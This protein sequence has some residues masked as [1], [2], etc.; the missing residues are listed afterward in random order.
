M[1]AEDAF[2]HPRRANGRLRFLESAVECS[3]DSRNCDRRTEERDR[4][5]SLPRRR[6]ALRKRLGDLG[7]SLSIR[8]STDWI[9]R[10]RTQSSGLTLEKN[11]RDRRQSSWSRAAKLIRREV[12]RNDRC[13]WLNRLNLKGKKKG[14]RVERNVN[15]NGIEC[16]K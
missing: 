16:K 10:R 8:S 9:H 4:G 11:L 12:K 2:S 7:I 3:D 13:D 14:K 6:T 5:A 1:H 15:G